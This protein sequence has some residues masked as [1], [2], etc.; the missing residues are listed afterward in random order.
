MPSE[1][2]SDENL[3]VII[4]KNGKVVITKAEKSIEIIRRFDLSS[5]ENISTEVIQLA[6]N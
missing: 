4:Y 2:S 6:D 3:E 5:K 1:K